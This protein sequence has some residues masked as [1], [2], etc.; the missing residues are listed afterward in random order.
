MRNILTTT[1][2]AALFACLC[3][4][5]TFKGRLIDASCLDQQQS[6]NSC[7][8]T[9]STTAYAIAV[10][11]K[12]Y[13]L[14]SDGNAKAADALKSHADRMADPNAPTKMEGVIATVKGTLAGE[15]LK[16]ESIE[17]Q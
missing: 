4:A 16:V 13:R 15:T 5:E 9:A 1:A 7:N 11:G 14:D 10:S 2:C 17:V 6:A 3:L 8:P 12:F